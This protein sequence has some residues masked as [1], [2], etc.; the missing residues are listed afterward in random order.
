MIAH[1]QKNAVPT[2]L[3]QEL[4]DQIVRL[5]R[6]DGLAIGAKVSENEL[7]SR[8]S[9]SRSPIRAA[10][11][12]L[13]VAGVVKHRPRRGMVVAAIPRSRRGK[14]EQILPAE[15]VL[16]WISRDRHIGAL[17][18]SLSEAG[19]MRRYK[20]PRAVVRSALQTLAELGLAERKSGYGWRLL[21]LWDD[22]ARLESYRFRIVVEP[23]AILSPNFSLTPE[24]IADMRG[25]HE[26][27]LTTAWTETTSIAF[28]EMNAAFHEG[29]AAGSG[30]RHFLAAIQRD[31]RLRRLSNYY[32]KHN[33]DRV[34]ANHSE[35]MAILDS[36]EA[37][38]PDVA[39]SLMR[40]HLRV[41]GTMPFHQAPPKASR[42]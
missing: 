9:V 23:A 2:R 1:A 35:H 33:F 16:V 21:T 39:A 11:N 30:N 37:N 10:L 19:L 32:W 26:F 22:D 34:R 5:I 6:A 27:M 29:I 8:L 41:A 4:V 40:A 13:A 38:Q 18:D 12:H 36:I 25:R 28:F 7:A 17:G 24:W 31:N 15:Q 20:M 3:Q 14:E 42:R